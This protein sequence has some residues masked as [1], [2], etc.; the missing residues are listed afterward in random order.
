MDELWLGCAQS[1]AEAAQCDAHPDMDRDPPHVP[2]PALAP[3]AV[4]LPHRGEERSIYTELRTCSRLQTLL[5][6]SFFARTPYPDIQD[7]NT[8]QVNSTVGAVIFETKIMAPTLSLSLLICK[9]TKNTR[10]ENI[11]ILRP[12]LRFQQQEQQQQQAES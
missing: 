4:P 5:N 3:A 1:P 12:R 10:N 6:S 11:I 8:L 7:I 2:R 9:S